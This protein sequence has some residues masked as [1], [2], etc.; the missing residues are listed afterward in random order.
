VSVADE[1][2]VYPLRA[3]RRWCR[4][5][6][7]ELERRIVGLRDYRIGRNPEPSEA[8]EAFWEL[9]VAD[10]GERRRARAVFDAAL[11]RDL[12]R[13]FDSAW[14]VRDAG[15]DV[16]ATAELFVDAIDE[17][18]LSVF[19]LGLW[20]GQLG[21]ARLPEPKGPGRTADGRG[22]GDSRQPWP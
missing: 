16:T 14:R 12:L 7:P 5:H 20:L 15:R 21:F 9:L 1:G 4:R 13:S 19:L 22:A 8:V 17:A 18:A 3:F 11:R 2:L 6:Y 10:I